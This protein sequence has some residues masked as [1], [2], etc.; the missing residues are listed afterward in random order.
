VGILT[1]NLIKL[2]LMGDRP[3]LGAGPNT[4]SRRV[5]PW[6][7]GRPGRIWRGAV[8]QRKR[9][10]IP[11][12]P[13]GNF[14]T[15]SHPRKGYYFGKA[16]TCRGPEGRSACNIVVAVYRNER[17]YLCSPTWQEW[18][19]RMGILDGGYFVCPFND[20]KR[21]NLLVSPT[22]VRTPRS[23]SARGKLQFPNYRNGSSLS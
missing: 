4:R 7:F 16:G 18:E 23:S 3:G 14:F 12:C 8:W 10:L 1:K 19:T 5:H 6:C 11:K 21:S 13:K 15:G 2:A 20:T 22:L 17:Q 9:R